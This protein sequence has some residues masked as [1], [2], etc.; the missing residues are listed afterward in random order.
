LKDERSRSLLKNGLSGGRFRIL[1][2]EILETL[3]EGCLPPQ[4]CVLALNFALEN[5]CSLQFSES[6]S[7]GIEELRT[8]HTRLLLVA[9]EKVGKYE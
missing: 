2:V 8:A 3:V 4:I 9:L 5:L 7:G 6:S 1:V